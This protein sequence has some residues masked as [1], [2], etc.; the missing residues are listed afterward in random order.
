MKTE[1][2]I[3]LKRR[4]ARRFVKQATVL[5]AVPD[6]EAITDAHHLLSPPSTAGFPQPWPVLWLVWRANLVGT[7][8]SSLRSLG[9]SGLDLAELWLSL[10]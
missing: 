7:G 10:S 8:L 4:E 2:D 1:A 3:T 5:A 6:P 9:S